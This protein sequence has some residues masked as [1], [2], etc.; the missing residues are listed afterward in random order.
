M[1]SSRLQRGFF[2]MVL[3][4]LVLSTLVV[5]VGAPYLKSAM[6]S[7]KN[8]KPAYE[9]M[10]RGEFLT[11][12]EY[13]T[14]DAEQKK[15]AKSAALTGVMAG[16]ITSNA[17]GPDD[18]AQKIIDKG[19]QVY[20]Q[21]KYS[22][23]PAPH[24]V[25]PSSL[26]L[27]QDGGKAL[28]R[29]ESGRLV[30]TIAIQAACGVTSSP[31]PVDVTAG[32]LP[33]CSSGTFVCGNSKVIC[34]DRLCNDTNDCGDNTDEGTAMCAQAQSCCQVTNGC[35]GETGSDCGSTCCCCPLGQAC[36]RVNPGRGCVASN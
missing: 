17:G 3:P 11:D 23:C 13:D 24:S 19:L 25:P 26:V 4:A 20:D 12:A 15:I 36:D 28:K 6:D 9:K 31:L 34:R 32:T 5:M 22:S 7:S 18:L 33:G 14:L 35:P 30:E 2:F 10:Q 1:K 21:S 8:M 27:A 16:Q 29:I